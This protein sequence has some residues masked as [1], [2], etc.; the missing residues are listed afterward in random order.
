VQRV[1]ARADGWQGE[2]SSVE[3]VLAAEQWARAR[4]H[5]LVDGGTVP[6]AAGLG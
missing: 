6:T 4:A 3:E 1:L 5:E 2:P